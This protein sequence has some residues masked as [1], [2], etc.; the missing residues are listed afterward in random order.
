MSWEKEIAEL[1]HREKLGRR[2]GGPE[3]VA[4]HRSQGKLTVR[5]RIDALLDPGSFYEI[6]TATGSG[7]YDEAG[8]LKAFTPANF[9]LGRG[10]IDGRR[11]VVA[12]DDFTVRGGANDAGIYEKALASER[13]ARDLRL[14]IVRLVDGT[15]G[16]GS[17]KNIEIKGHTLLPGY[18]GRKWVVMVENLSLVPV[19]GLALGSTAGL[20]AAR[21][22][23]S[24]YSVIVKDTAQMFVAGPPVVARIGEQLGKNELGGSHIHAQNGAVDDEAESEQDAFERARRFLS[25]LPSSVYELPP[26]GPREDDPNRREAWLISAIPRNRKRL[27]DMRRIID[28][29]VDKDSFFEMGRQWGCSMITG[30]AR[31]DGW[32]VALMANDPRVYAGA[33]TAVASEKVERFVDVAE[34]FHLPVVYLVDNPGYMI[35]LEAEQQATIRYGVKALAAVFQSR[36]PWCAVIVRKAFGVAGSGHMNAERYGVRVAWPSGDWGSLPVEGGIE[37][38]YKADIAAAPDPEKRFA[39]IEAKLEQLRSPLR[40]AEAFIPE[41]IIDPRDTRPLLCEFAEMAA[42]LRVPGPRSF[43][44]RP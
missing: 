3:K 44:F 38:A 39:E 40:S 28:A 24:H 2:M 17:V 12:G 16:G 26:R 34:I 41:E 21:V 35:G 4:R 29:L 42:P 1:R 14:P 19:V 15:G 32:P 37:A 22:A 23:A 30:F 25:Y 8:E 10:K 13:M 11:V 27:Y 43:G 18:D 33:W 7:E 6:G 31:L 9:V 5:E 20:G 36:V